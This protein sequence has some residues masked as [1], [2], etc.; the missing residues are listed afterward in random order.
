MILAL[1]AKK[2]IAFN[3]LYIINITP[4]KFVVC[5]GNGI[6]PNLKLD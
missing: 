1:H 2:I 5:N 4:K 6:G 3:W